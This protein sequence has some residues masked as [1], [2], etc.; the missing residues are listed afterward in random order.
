MYDERLFVG[1]GDR[2]KRFVCIVRC[3]DGTFAIVRILPEHSQCE[4]RSNPTSHFFSCRGRCE[5]FLSGR[6][7]STDRKIS[8][9]WTSWC[10]V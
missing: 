3:N 10:H 4:I 6:S 5:P 9:T 8:P 7:A 2:K 1:G